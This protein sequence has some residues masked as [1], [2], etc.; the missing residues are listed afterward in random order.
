MR[1]LVPVLL[2]VF[3][4]LLLAGAVGWGLIGNAVDHPTAI[5]LPTQI[6][7]LGRIRYITG[8]QAV[9]EFSSLHGE[10]F[11]L[12]SGAVASYG[13]DGQI[14]V[15]A[16]GAPLDFQTGQLVA[17]MHAK[18]SDGNS[19]FKEV[20]IFQQSGRTIYA[21]QGMGQNHYYFQSKNLVIWLAAEPA[22][23]DEALQQTLEEFP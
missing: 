10:Q 6:A 17:E 12:T 14:T 4:V 23:A 19:P 18:I 3:G 15:W 13:R 1:R 8:Q 9:Q 2:A 7:G 11:A 21:V 22:I 5:A 20:G 16:A